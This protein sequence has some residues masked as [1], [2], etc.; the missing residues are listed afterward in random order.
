MKNRPSIFVC[1]PW[2]CDATHYTSGACGAGTSTASAGYRGQATWAMRTK[3]RGAAEAKEGVSIAEHAGL[4]IFPRTLSLWWLQCK[5]PH[6]ILDGTYS[7]PCHKQ[8]VGADERLHVSTR[9]P[10]RVPHGIA[11][12]VTMAGCLVLA[13]DS[14]C[15]LLQIL[16]VY[17]IHAHPCYYYNISTCFANTVAWQSKWTWVESFV[18]LQYLI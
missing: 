1:P 13:F 14:F 9:H 8:D 5:W 10:L 11:D 16:S 2:R 15:Y 12:V 3:D 18:F 17:G 4:G 6:R 7:S